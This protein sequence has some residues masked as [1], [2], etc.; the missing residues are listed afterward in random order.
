M[1]RSGF[2]FCESVKSGISMS[3][4]LRRF[5]SES[6][7]LPITEAL[8]GKYTLNTNPLMVNLVSLKPQRKIYAELRIMVHFLCAPRVIP[9]ISRLKRL[10][11]AQAS[12]A[13]I[14]H[15]QTK[16]FIPCQCPG[17]NLQSAPPPALPLRS[18]PHFTPFSLCYRPTPTPFHPHLLG[19][20]RWG[21]GLVIIHTQRFD[22]RNHN[23]S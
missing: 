12:P 1:K 5:A 23:T 10:F 17:K 3:S 18:T 15:G 8:N 20:Q 19:F 22:A 16:Q 4:S 7:S 21:R 9:G 13:N 6:S 11:L 14:A 2:Q